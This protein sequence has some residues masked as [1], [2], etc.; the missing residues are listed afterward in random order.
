MQADKHLT[1]VHATH[2]PAGFRWRAM[3][4]IIGATNGPDCARPFAHVGR[5]EGRSRRMGASWAAICT[6]CS[7][8]M[9]FAAFIASLGARPSGL[10]YGA[11]VEAALDALADHMEAHADVA[12]LLA[13]AQ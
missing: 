10:S 13:L 9:P 1:Q 8:R 6:A 4:S 3:K 11:V 2:A 5:P 7:R 12:G